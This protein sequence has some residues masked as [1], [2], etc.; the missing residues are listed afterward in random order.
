M[1]TKLTLTAAQDALSR[2]PQWQAERN[3]LAKLMEHHQTGKRITHAEHQAL[4]YDANGQYRP[5]VAHEYSNA[6]ML[7]F[8]R[9]IDALMAGTQTADPAPPPASAPVEEKPVAPQRAGAST[10]MSMAAAKALAAIGRTGREPEAQQPHPTE[11]EAGWSNAIAGIAPRMPGA[12][13][14]AD[15]HDGKSADYFRSNTDAA[16][17]SIVE[18]KFI[19]PSPAVIK[20]GWAKAV[21]AHSPAVSTEP[22]AGQE[23]GEQARVHA[24]WDAAIAS[25]G[26]R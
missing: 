25:Q 3:A 26:G 21:A 13:I 1:P 24:G 17:A 23:G 11:A 8:G 2:D 20:Q 7:E 16:P 22:S 15:G 6:S 9:R 19:E 5:S 12:K 14:P 10:S 18:T 4:F